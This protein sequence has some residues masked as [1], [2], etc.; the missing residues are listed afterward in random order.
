[1]RKSVQQAQICDT[2]GDRPKLECCTTKSHVDGHV[3]TEVCN[4]CRSL[5]KWLHCL[6]NRHSPGRL[7]G[8][9]ERV[10]HRH[11]CSICES[12]EKS[13]GCCDNRHK[14]GKMTLCLCAVNTKESLNQV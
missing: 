8:I 4:T 2:C 10:V 14:S 13:D 3:L 1:M 9:D 11:I 6:D 5:S 12:L 7:A